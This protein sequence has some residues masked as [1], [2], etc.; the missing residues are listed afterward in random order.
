[1]IKLKVYDVGHQFPVDYPVNPSPL[2][3]LTDEEEERVLV[4]TI[5]PAEAVAIKMKLTPEEDAFPRPM[6][7]AKIKG[8]LALERCC[9]G[10]DSPVHCRFQDGNIRHDLRVVG[11]DI[12][13]LRRN[14]VD[15]AGSVRFLVSVAAGAE[16]HPRDDVF[17]QAARADGSVCG[18]DDVRL[19]HRLLHAV[20][21]WTPRGRGA[22]TETSIG[23]STG[24]RS[25]MVRALR[26]SGGDR[27]VLVA[28]THA[29]QGV[30]SVGRNVRHFVASLPVCRSGRAFDPLFFGGHTGCH[31]R[32]CRNSIRGAAFRKNRNRNF[33]C[34]SPVDGAVCVV[35]P[36]DRKSGNLRFVKI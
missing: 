19:A 20:F 24:T 27:A 33:A 5:G 7:H 13:P 18:T 4:L 11:G 32:S 21:R 31:L 26:H 8:L 17:P 36:S 9:S 30:R 16:R 29:V 6:T 12:T 1:M 22:I 28:A 25:R 10:W 34:D 2:L 3:W 23:A 35:A 15:V 14:R